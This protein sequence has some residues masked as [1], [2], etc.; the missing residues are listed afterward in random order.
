MRAWEEGLSALG[1]GSVLEVGNEGVWDVNLASIV[2][3]INQRYNKKREEAI[4][5]VKNINRKVK[6]VKD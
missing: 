4:N 3:K 5:K 6:N 1:L 2:K